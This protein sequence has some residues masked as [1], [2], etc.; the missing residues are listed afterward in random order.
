MTRS[1]MSCESACKRRNDGAQ[2]T[3]RTWPGAWHRDRA[4]SALF[5]ALDEVRQQL[6]ERLTETL[7]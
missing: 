7:D 3:L 4:R 1:D 2:R 6:V 5:R